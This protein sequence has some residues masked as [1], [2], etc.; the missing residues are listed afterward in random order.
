LQRQLIEFLATV[1]PNFIATHPQHSGTL[2]KYLIGKKNN[3]NALLFF[4]LGYITSL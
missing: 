3:N 1:T 4:D 2:Q